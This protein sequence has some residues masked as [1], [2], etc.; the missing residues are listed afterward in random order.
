[1]S[2]SA[3]DT[4][5][6]YPRLRN[7][8]EANVASNLATYSQTLLTYLKTNLP[9]ARMDDVIGRQ[10]IT[11]Y[12]GA[13]LRQTSLPY[14]ATAIATFDND[15]PNSLRTTL[16]IRGGGTL[17]VTYFADVIYGKMLTLE[18]ISGTQVSLKQDGVAVAT[19]GVGTFLTETPAPKLTFDIN[20][21][22]AASSGAYM[23]RQLIQS[24][25]IKNGPVVIFSGWGDVSADFAARLANRVGSG[26][27]VVTSV[28]QKCWI[29][30]EGQPVCTE[31]LSQAV[32]TNDATGIRAATGWLAQFSR[33]AKVYARF[34]VV[35]D[36][37]VAE[38]VGDDVV[39]AIDGSCYQAAV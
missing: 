21:P 13:P 9:N 39:D 12:Y 20:H 26:T 3:S 31:P 16:R 15:I 8:N 10:K 11:P 28:R 17:D 36:Q 30:S 24:A 2:G 32:T 18:K 34:A 33:M 37:A 22:Y 38:F 6:G 7:A 14:T 25:F 35:R 4:A 29:D 23:D 27:V 5:N 1:M 19:V